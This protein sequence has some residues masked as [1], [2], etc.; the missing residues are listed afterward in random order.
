MYRYIT[1]YVQISH[2]YMYNIKFDFFL[3]YYLCLN[4]NGQCTIARCSECIFTLLAFAHTAPFLGTFFP[5]DRI[6]FVLC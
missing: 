4:H 3:L 5:H 2:A 1:T 6:L